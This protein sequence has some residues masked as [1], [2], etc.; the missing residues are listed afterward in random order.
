MPETV[1]FRDI[2]G[3]VPVKDWLVNVVARRDPRAA[4]KCRFLLDLL[5]T[6]GKE[7]RR[8]YSDY[9]RDGIYELRARAGSVNYR[10]LYFFSGEYAAVISNGL[11]KE[12]AVPDKEIDLTIK[13]KA[14]F[15]QNPE[16][17]SYAE[18]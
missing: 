5:R 11:T 18:E 12:S 9:L 16:E 15:E 10:L 7:L 14:T 6:K 13:R 3:S 1:F 4:A 8:P 17:C 2:D